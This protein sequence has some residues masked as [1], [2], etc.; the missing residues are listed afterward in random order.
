[1]QY[2]NSKHPNSFKNLVSNDWKPQSRFMCN[3]ARPI[4]ESQ[5]Y[6]KQ[7][8]SIN[9]SQ[10]HTKVC[11]PR[12]TPEVNLEQYVSKQSICSFFLQEQYH[13]IKAQAPASLIHILHS[14]R[15][16]C[17]THP[18]FLTILHA[19][20]CGAAATIP[21]V[22]F[23][24]YVMVYSCRHACQVPLTHTAH[25]LL[26]RHLSPIQ[27]PGIACKSRTASSEIGH[28]QKLICHTVWATSFLP[29]ADSGRWLP[30]CQ[31]L[32]GQET[33]CGSLELCENAHTCCSKAAVLHSPAQQ[34]S[35]YC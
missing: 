29:T 33:I 26:P 34:H 2:S 5:W 17:F 3:Y 9:N 7:S 25:S 19:S 11:S 21:P 24:S 35:S 32:F 1:M 6:S 30:S 12:P 16:K 14:G 18:L 20:E 28:A 8:H 27:T 15:T 10:S 22:V 13:Q 31:K 23:P 4:Y